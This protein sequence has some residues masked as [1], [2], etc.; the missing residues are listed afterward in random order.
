MTQN[1]VIRKE[2]QMEKKMIAKYALPQVIRITVT[3][4]LLFWYNCKVGTVFLFLIPSL[5]LC[6]DENSYDKDE[7]EVAILQLAVGCIMYISML[8]IIFPKVRTTESIWWFIIAVFGLQ[9]VY[10]P[11]YEQEQKMIEKTNE[12][13]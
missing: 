3:L 6:R 7:R 2:D 10:I 12:L 4:L 11:K 13:N 1:C 9:L 8:C 5:V